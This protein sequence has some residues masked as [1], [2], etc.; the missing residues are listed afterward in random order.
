MSWLIRGIV[1][2]ALIL[3]ALSPALAFRG[4]HQAL[5]ARPTPNADEAGARGEQ[6]QAVGYSAWSDAQASPDQVGVTRHDRKRAAAGYNLFTDYS[7]AVSLMDMDGKV[8][9]TWTLPAGEGA[10]REL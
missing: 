7:D 3:G 6:L 4:G 8:V 1:S 10:Q 5:P 2:S 9:H